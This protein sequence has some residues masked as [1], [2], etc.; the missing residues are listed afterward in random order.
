MG[1]AKRAFL[2]LVRKR[3]KSILLF[4][5]LLVLTTLVLSAVSIG[6]AAE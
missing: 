3:S 6:N 2:Y 1:A 5:I 4:V